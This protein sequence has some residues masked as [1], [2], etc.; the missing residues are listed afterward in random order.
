MSIR[1]KLKINFAEQIPDYGFDYSDN[2]YCYLENIY[3]KNPD[4]LKDCIDAI[5]MAYA[6]GAEHDIDF[7]KEVLRSNLSNNRN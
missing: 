5:V 3:L 7:Y 6:M 1:T 4:R 2:V